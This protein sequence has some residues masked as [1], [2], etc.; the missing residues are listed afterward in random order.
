MCR[1]VSHIQ[2]HGHSKKMFHYFSSLLA[3]QTANPKCAKNLPLPD[4]ITKY[5]IL[6]VKSS[7]IFI[8]TYFDVALSKA[9]YSTL[10]TFHDSILLQIAFELKTMLTLRLN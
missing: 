2:P 7:S 10:Y 6:K 3:N 5:H 1:D 9:T 4:S 8:H